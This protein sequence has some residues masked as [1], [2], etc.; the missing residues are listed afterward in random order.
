MGN[1]IK[2][3][4]SLFVH[5]MNLLIRTRVLRDSSARVDHDTALRPDTALI[6]PTFRATYVADFFVLCIIVG[7]RKF[8]VVSAA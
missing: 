7:L 4:Q 2:L 6:Q 1:S 3:N 8:Y 5:C